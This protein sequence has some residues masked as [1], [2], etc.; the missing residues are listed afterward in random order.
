MPHSFA[1]P[2]FVSGYG[3]LTASYNDWN[4]GS[5]IRNRVRY[6]LFFMKSWEWV[7]QCTVESWSKEVLL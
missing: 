5:T 2:V 6:K 1:Y 3:T 4:K 7:T